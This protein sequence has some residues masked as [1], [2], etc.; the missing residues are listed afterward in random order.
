MHQI[1][2]SILDGEQFEEL[3]EDLFKAMGFDDPL[4]ERSGRG[5]DGGKDLIVSEKRESGV[6][7][8]PRRFK[9]LVE[10]KNFAKSGKS[11]RPD[12]VGSITDK[13]VTHDADGY[14]LV[15]STGPSINVATTIKSIDESDR[16]NFEAT[17]WA[18][19]RLIDEILKHRHVLEKYFPTSATVFPP[20]SHW[21]KH[22]PFLELFP[23]EDSQ[24][25]YFFGRQTEVTEVIERIYQQNFILLYGESGVGKTSLS[26]AGILPI[27][28]NEGT[29]AVVRKVDGSINL[30]SLLDSIKSLLPEN[31]KYKSVGNNSKDDSSLLHLAQIAEELRKQDLRLTIFFDQFETI[32]QEVDPNTKQIGQLFSEIASH[33]KAHRNISVVF[34]LRADYLDEFGAWTTEHKI[35]ELWQNSYP[36]RKLS[37]E[38]AINVLTSVPKHVSAKFSDDLIEL[39]VNDL[40]NLDRGRIYP[41]NLQIVA[42]QIF[43]QARGSRALEKKD[44]LEIG[45]DS[46]SR[47]DVKES[48]SFFNTEKETQEKVLAFLHQH[49]PLPT[50][51]S[52]CC[53]APPTRL[54]QAP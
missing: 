52:N 35:P 37:R 18:G 25:S 1:D 39:I 2:F 36:I 16:F 41:P 30:A 50:R 26:Q 33:I 40:Q 7:G 38:Q 22:N 31:V 28:R 47:V 10:C 51:L 32:F 43:E 6:L 17:C 24:S 5:P 9:W 15:T 14:L 3:C 45:G 27:L 13:L 21:S 54:C 49:C 44:I 34:S 48:F 19:N 46:L 42:S 8:A 12:D 20:T 53:A 4:P 23:Y 11:V 29:I